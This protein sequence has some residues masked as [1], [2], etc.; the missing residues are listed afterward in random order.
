MKIGIDARTLVKKKA[1][2][3]YYLE[4]LLINIL[5]HDCINSY[6]LFSD[7]KIYFD[8]KKCD[9]LFYIEY[10]Q[11]II[12]KKSMFYFFFLGSI[13]KNLG[14]ELDIF[15]GS[16]HLLPI[17]LNVNVKKLLTIHDLV[18]YEYPSTTT[19]YN[20]VIS[21]L[22]VPFSIKNA[23]KIFAISASTKNGIIKY[24]PGI[25]EKNIEIIYLGADYLNPNNTLLKKFYAK[26][27]SINCLISGNYLLYVG[28]I[29]P[30][31]NLDYLLDAFEKIKDKN[32]LYLIICG[33]VGWK[34]NKVVNRINNLVKNGSV[35]YLSYV[36][37]ED[38]FLL[39]KNA[40]AFI[41]PSLYEGFGL[42]VVEAM[43]MGTVAL[44][45][46]NSSLNELIE[47]DEL[48]FDIDD[49]NELIDKI[50]KLYNDINFYTKCEKYCKERS[51][52]FSWKKSA[53]KYIKVFNSFKQ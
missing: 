16:Q 41:F 4:N 2:L 32:D 43:K 52:F 42:P 37:N 12:F 10:K 36:T 47:M 45:A 9:N 44:V 35:F 6:Y 17:S 53:D 29:E 20:L 14:L 40:F 5:E 1:G 26:Y 21:R 23:D 51:E 18:Y 27:V 25:N 33:K 48:K 24:F 39:M 34:S 8:H 7:R 30:R 28:T 38:K 3:G 13:I 31:K 15:W 50:D 11:G 19:Y 49:K 46:N 22:F